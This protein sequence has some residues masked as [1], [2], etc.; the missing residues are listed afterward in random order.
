MFVARLTTILVQPTELR[1]KSQ[2]EQIDEM[3]ENVFDLLDHMAKKKDELNEK[4]VPTSICT[5]LQQ[6]VRDT[7]VNKHLF[8]LDLRHSRFS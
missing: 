3:R 1:I 2:A 4:S 8:P 5:Q 7:E 6:A